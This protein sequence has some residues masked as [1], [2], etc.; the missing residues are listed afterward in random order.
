MSKEMLT[1]FCAATTTAKEDRSAHTNQ[2]HTPRWESVCAL[3]VSHL[4]LR[5][6]IA[7]TFDEE[8]QQRNVR[9]LTPRIDERRCI[10]GC[11]RLMNARTALEQQQLCHRQV[12]SCAGAVQ[13]RVAIPIGVVQMQR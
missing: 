13:S 11:I 2:R 3:F 8:A 12:T 1:P 10:A 7:A 4:V 6:H 9:L 5:V